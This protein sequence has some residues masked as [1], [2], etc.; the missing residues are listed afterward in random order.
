MGLRIL[1]TTFLI[2]LASQVMAQHAIFLQPEPAKPAEAPQSLSPP[3][4]ATPIQDRETRPVAAT[5]VT[6]A[7]KVDVTVPAEHRVY[8]VPG[9]TREV[10]LTSKWLFGEVRTECRA[11]LIPVRWKNAAPRGVR[12]TQYG[13]RVC[14]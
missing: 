9:V 12:V 14:H 10:C 11:C 5:I 7:P 1:L 6:P 4:V 3:P 13:Q 2:C 8:L